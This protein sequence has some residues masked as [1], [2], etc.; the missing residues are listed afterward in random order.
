[1]MVAL[2]IAKCAHKVRRE[3]VGQ[4]VFPQSQLTRQAAAKPQNPVSYCLHLRAR[5]QAFRSLEL[6]VDQADHGLRIDSLGE[7]V[8]PPFVEVGSIVGTSSV[9]CGQ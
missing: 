9:Y 6:P 2:S 4:R 1:M 7:P 5:R 3:L 8:V